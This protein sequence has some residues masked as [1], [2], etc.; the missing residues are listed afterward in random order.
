MNLH[1]FI[2]MG[3]LLGPVQPTEKLYLGFHSG[4]WQGRRLASDVSHDDWIQ[5]RFVVSVVERDITSP[6]WATSKSTWQAWPKNP[7]MPAGPFCTR[8]IATTILRKELG[9]HI[10]EMQRSYGRDNWY[11]SCLDFHRYE[12]HAEGPYQSYRW[13]NRQPVIPA[14]APQPDGPP[15]E[16]N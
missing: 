1:A 5:C 4:D 6:Q 14:P 10:T 9:T 13:G 3:I 12:Y 11:E 2:V 15:E 7:D 16:G 8:G